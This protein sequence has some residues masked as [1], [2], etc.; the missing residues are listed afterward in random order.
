[1]TT[2]LFCQHKAT[3]EGWCPAC[4]QELMDD[5]RA[6]LICLLDRAAEEVCPWCDR[7]WP[8]AENRAVHISPANYAKGRPCMGQRCRAM[9]IKALKPKENNG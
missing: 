3:G 4:V 8:I 6:E 5:H 9:A 7:G 2:S 1:M